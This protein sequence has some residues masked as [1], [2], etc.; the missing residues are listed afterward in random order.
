MPIGN[1]RCHMIGVPST[2]DDD[3]STSYNMTTGRKLPAALSDSTAG[4]YPCLSIRRLSGNRNARSLGSAP[5]RHSDFMPDGTRSQICS[6][7][8]CVAPLRTVV[9]P[10]PW[11]SMKL[12]LRATRR[13]G[14]R[15]VS[16]TRVGLRRHPSIYLRLSGFGARAATHSIT[17]SA[18]ASSYCGTALASA[19]AVLRF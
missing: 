14:Q 18:F 7:A 2:G 13:T 6:V 9:P 3:N 4:L 16:L 5:C 15:Q 10:C 1:D 17:S 12:L 19:L 8:P 11:A